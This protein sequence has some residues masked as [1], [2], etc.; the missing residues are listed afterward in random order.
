MDKVILT[1]NLGV[2]AKIIDVSGHHG[3]TFNVATT[4]RH[5][6]SKGVWGNLTTWY[7][8]TKWDKK[9]YLEKL[10]PYFKKGSKVY[11]DGQLTVTVFKDNPQLSVLVSEM[12]LIS[13][14][15]N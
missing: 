1:G 13:S 7:K 8:V 5:R 10:V 12:E 2:D 15:K 6:D 9:D 11:V 14:P 3:I 4:R